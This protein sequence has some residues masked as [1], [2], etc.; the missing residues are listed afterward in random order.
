MANAAS[1]NA[2]R[3]CSAL[4]PGTA[5]AIASVA[6]TAAPAATP[7]GT[8]KLSTLRTNPGW[9]RGAPGASARKNPGTPIVRLDISVRCRGKNGWLAPPAR[10]RSR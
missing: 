5:C 6:S 8:A 2:V 3:A 9:A 1:M 10:S 7:A 4:T